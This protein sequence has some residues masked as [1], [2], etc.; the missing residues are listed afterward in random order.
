MS[1]PPTEIKRELKNYIYQQLRGSLSE[2]KLNW[3]ALDRVNTHSLYHQIIDV[4][5][6]REPG[7]EW[8]TGMFNKLVLF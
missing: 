1:E 4:R 3:Q 8:E 5:I 2:G 7:V 6:H